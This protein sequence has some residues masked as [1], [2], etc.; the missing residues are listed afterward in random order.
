MSKHPFFQT[1]QAWFERNFS[2]PDAISLFITLVIAVLV[3][4][5]FGRIL[6]PVLISVIVAYM[7]NPAVKL[8]VRCGCPRLLS[9]W[10]VYIIFL[11]VF[12]YAMLYLTPLIWRQFLNLINQLPN[13]FLM[14][15]LWA[16]QF[17]EKHK[18]ILSDADVGHVLAYFKEQSPKLG[19]TLLRLSWT[20]IPSMAEIILYVVLVPL[21]VFFFL[22]DSTILLNW[23][24]RFL[25]R[26]RRLLRKVFLEVYKKIGA[27]VK[28]RVIEIFI[29][30]FAGTV[31]FELLDLQYA[32]LMGTLLGISV[33]VPY[34]GAIIVTIP[35]I[36]LGLIQW[37]LTAHFW[38]LLLVFAVIIAVDG[39]ILFPLLFAQ[40]MDLHP[41]VII[42][43]VLI[44]GAIWGFWGIFFAIPLAT[45]VNAVLHAWPQSP[46]TLIQGPKNKGSSF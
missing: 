24:K 33:I 43:S 3:I 14:A 39:N 30:G 35:V 5:L 42:L 12:I 13:Y 46:E 8:L 27:Y 22:K 2:D 32:I 28:G 41:V 45:L 6:M 10:I 40:T 29:V 20:A 18:W 11:G 34:I 16:A 36:I 26:R 19:Q 4:E 25:P 31:A 37:G 44:F 38:Y 17:M 21:L 15:Q 7:L 23:F 9:V 1:I